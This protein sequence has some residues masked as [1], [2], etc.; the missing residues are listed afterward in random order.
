MFPRSFILS[1]SLVLHPFPAFHLFSVNALP[2]FSSTPPSVPSP[3]PAGFS[4]LLHLWERP[5]D[6]EMQQLSAGAPREQEEADT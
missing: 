2:F 5:N 6:A 3:L 1:V 4:L